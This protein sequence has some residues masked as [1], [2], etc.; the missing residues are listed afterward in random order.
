MY[1]VIHT[2]PT[3]STTWSFALIEDTFD[4][5]EKVKSR[6]ATEDQVKVINEYSTIIYEY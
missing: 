2:T 6:M 5:V 1:K 4:Q 3:T